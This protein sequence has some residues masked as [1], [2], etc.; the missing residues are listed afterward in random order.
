LKR[1]APLKEALDKLK[2]FFILGV[3]TNNPVSVARKTFKALGV[4]NSFSVLV[5]LDTCMKPKPHKEPFFKFIELSACSAGN[6]VS[7]GDRFDIDI[8]IPLEIGMGGILVEGGEGV[9]RLLELLSCNEIK[10]NP[11]IDY[12]I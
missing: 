12:G 1:D 3:I 5:G 2:E 6:C 8:R 9:Y 10:S 11:I 7:V 4:E